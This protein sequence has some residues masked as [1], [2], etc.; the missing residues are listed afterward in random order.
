MSDF[1]RAIERVAGHFFSFISFHRAVAWFRFEKNSKEEE[2]C[3]IREILSLLRSISPPFCV[4]LFFFGIEI[5]ARLNKRCDLE[6]Y[7]VI[8]KNKK[9]E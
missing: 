2:R 5:V 7:Y 8:F 3:E 6:F 1:L 4:F 9:G